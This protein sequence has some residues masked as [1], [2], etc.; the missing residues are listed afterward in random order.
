MNKNGSA[1]NSVYAYIFYKKGSE[2]K[3]V[4]ARIDTTFLFIKKISY[5]TN[6]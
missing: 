5:S 2:S 6:L 1:S 4:T 3:K